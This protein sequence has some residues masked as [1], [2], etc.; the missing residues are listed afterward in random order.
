MD[1]MD[2]N[3]NNQTFGY[4]PYTPNNN[5]MPGNN[6]TP[7][8]KPKSKK[9]YGLS[10]VILSVVLAAVIGG[11]TGAVSVFTLNKI[12]DTVY[13][14]GSENSTAQQNT[15]TNISIDESV[16]SVIEAV[17]LKVTPSVVGIATTAATTSFF[18]GSTESTGEGSGIVYSADGY[19]ITN[20]HVIESAVTSSSSKIEVFLNGDTE[21]GYQASVVGYNISND[22][23]VLKI[24]VTGLTAIELGNA[25]EL[26]VGQYVAA[27][28]SPGGLEFMGSVTYGIISG[29][30]RVI[31][32]S[33]TGSEVNLI[34][35][36][37]AI[38]P[39][40]S[41]GAL[42]NTKGQLIG[43]NSSKIAATEYE[44]MGFA[45]PIDTVKE[46]CDKIIANENDP[47]PYIGVTI[48]EKYDAEILEKLGYPAGAVVKSVMSGGPAYESGI[49]SG[50]IIVEF[51]G[52]AISDY[53]ELNDAVAASTVGSTVKVKI[54]RSGK[55]YTTNVKI[56]SNNSQ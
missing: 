52:E 43:I 26:R 19:I 39:G 30:N 16:E 56:R 5:Y 38:N 54:Y 45:I 20:Y 17:A 51:N 23:A 24:S 53:N 7:K 49:R 25:D 11:T 35:T 28:G 18:G 13:G 10:T 22:L 33:S 46:I 55:Y 27:I 21:N 41:G 42:V 50:D 48:S 29:L 12:S 44:G 37:A 47:N 8:P 4:T 32:D 40:N 6:Y 3:F 2:D 1:Y 36:D 14:T 15:V 34:Q 31:S 9:K